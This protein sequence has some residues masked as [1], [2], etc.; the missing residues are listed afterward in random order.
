MPFWKAKSKLAGRVFAI[1]CLRSTIDE[2]ELS[3]LEP[4]NG[5]AGHDQSPSRP[6]PISLIGSTST[7]ADPIIAQSDTTFSH[8]DSI[9]SD[10]PVY[11]AHNHHRYETDFSH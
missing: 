4:T 5:L 2:E 8:S 3:H 7:G 11:Q 1:L 9:S 6:P 10:D